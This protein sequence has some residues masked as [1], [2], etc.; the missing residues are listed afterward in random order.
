MDQGAPAEPSAPSPLLS[1]PFA[2]APSSL[3]PGFHSVHYYSLTSPA[4]ATI[5]TSS[6]LQPL[7]A[8]V[9]TFTITHLDVHPIA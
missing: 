2:S 8:P 9:A 7:P 4:P 6:L 1:H 3:V 5:L